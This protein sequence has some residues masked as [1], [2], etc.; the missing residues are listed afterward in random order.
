MQ[1]HNRR[2]YMYKPLFWLFFNKSDFLLTAHVIFVIEEKPFFFCLFVCWEWPFLNFL[3]ISISFHIFF[4]LMTI[5]ISLNKGNQE[6]AEDPFGS[7]KTDKHA[8]CMFECT[9]HNLNWLKSNSMPSNFIQIKFQ[10]G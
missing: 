8:I 6:H 5:I 4:S 3:S 9:L 2:F 7:P 10:Q 1:P